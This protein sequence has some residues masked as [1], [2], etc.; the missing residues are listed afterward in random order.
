MDEIAA[1]ILAAGRATRWRASGG[2]EATAQ[3]SKLV[4]DYR[5]RPI[6]RAVALSALASRARPALVVVGHDAQAVRA[7]LEGLNVTFVDNPRFAEGLSTSLRA[8][9]SAVPARCAGAVMLLGD[10]PEVSAALIDAL[11]G[12]FE[13]RPG[14]R[15]AAPLRADGLGNPALLARA[16]FGEAM[17]LEGDR[18]ARALIE[19]AGADRVEIEWPGREAALDIDDLAAWRRAQ[20]DDL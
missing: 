15:A 1:V 17:A 13:A 6:V 16:M 7:A 18:G 20:D 3:A 11:I 5:G 12:G 2:A 9:L 19:T 4:A 8:G 14:A 10:M